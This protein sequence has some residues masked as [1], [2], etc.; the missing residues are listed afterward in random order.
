MPSVIGYGE[1]GLTYWALNH[2]LGEVLTLLEGES[3]PERSV[4]FFR[5]SFG[6][7]GGIASPQFGEFDAILSSE[8]WIYLIESK[9]DGSPAVN[10]QGL[11]QL[12]PRQLL[13]HGIFRW[14]WDRW[15]V[16][17]PPSWASFRLANEQGFQAVFGGKPLAPV[18]SKLA[19]NLE[20]ILRCLAGRS[21]RKVQ[22]LL[23]YFHREGFAPPEQVAAPPLGLAVDPAFVLRPFAY[24]PLG[25]SLYFEVE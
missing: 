20:H 7:A 9:W 15:H 12:E 22:N 10:P 17:N 16:Q 25:D 21:A 4:L 18:G 13:R 8:R 5:P 23:L 11:V 6:R 2:R 24:E 1:D 14:I 3:D 19:R